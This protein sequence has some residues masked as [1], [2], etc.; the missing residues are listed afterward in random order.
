MMED[1]KSFNSGRRAFLKH[2]GMGVGAAVSMTMMEPF[3]VFAQKKEEQ[4]EVANRMT[5]R[6]QHGS[7]EQI[8]CWDSA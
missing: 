6:V 5:Y 1:K 2:L 7:G 4:G 8:S 3:Q